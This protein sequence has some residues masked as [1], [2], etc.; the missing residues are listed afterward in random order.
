[1]ETYIN[2]HCGR[3]SC[4]KL[5]EEEY[6]TWNHDQAVKVLHRALFQKW[7]YKAGNT[8]YNDSVERI[9]DSEKCNIL[10]VGDFLILTAKKLE[11]NRPII[12]IINK[13]M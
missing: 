6:G 12:T 5:T 3:M 2:I 1:M 10:G 8:W 4:P 9:L 13:E 11:N 7:G